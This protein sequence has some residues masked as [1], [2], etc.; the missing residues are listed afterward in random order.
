[1]FIRPSQSRRGLTLLEVI[2]SI[3]ILGMS[4]VAIGQLV[5]LGYRSARQAQLRSDANIYADAK[6]AEVVAGVLELQSVSSQPLV[7]DRDWLY[8][9]S[10][11]ASDHLGLLSVTVNVTQNPEIYNPPV[12]LSIT[13]FVPDPD[14]DPL[15]DVE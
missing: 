4:L 7:Q 3:A 1:M 13:R 10:V 11:E 2:L 15:E 14:F 8:G 12:S 6:M 9:I 5:N